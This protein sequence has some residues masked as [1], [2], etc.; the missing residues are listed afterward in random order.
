[1]TLEVGVEALLGVDARKLA[2][3]DLDG[4]D[5]GIGKLGLGAALR[6]L[7]ALEPIVGEAE[8]GRDEGAE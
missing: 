6:R 4:Q 2:H 5:L 7:L 8:N 1:V 3:D